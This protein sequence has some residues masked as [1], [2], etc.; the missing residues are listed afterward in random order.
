MLTRILSML[1]VLALSLS[2]ALAADADLQQYN[3]AAIDVEAVCGANPLTS[4]LLLVRDGKLITADANGA[5]RAPI[6]RSVRLMADYMTCVRCMVSGACAGVNLR[7]LKSLHVDGSGGAVSSATSNTIK[8]SSGSGTAEVG[9]GGF[10]VTA[11]GGGYHQMSDGYSKFTNTSAGGGNPLK[12]IPISNEVRPINIVKA[13]FR[14]TTDGLGNLSIID[15]HNISSCSIGATN[16]IDCTMSITLDSTNYVALVNGQVSAV[17]AAMQCSPQTGSTMTCI[18]QP[19][20][21]PVLSCATNQCVMSV[22]VVGRL[23]T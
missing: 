13:W 19:I 9:P 3:R 6:N 4:S 15:G 2:S 7:T 8:V 16:T 14:V 20:S 18:F 5:F 11:A 10:Q 21:G 22:I 17:T 23:T 1:C 12:N